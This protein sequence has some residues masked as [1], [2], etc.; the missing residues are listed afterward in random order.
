MATQ[1]GSFSHGVLVESD[2]ESLL[3]VLLMPVVALRPEHML[4][5]QSGCK[6]M[7]WVCNAIITGAVI[8]DSGLNQ[9]EGMESTKKKGQ[10]GECLEGCLGRQDA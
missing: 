8:R 1:P 5:D 10:G 2:R 7:R 6:W 9:R 3:R 4:W